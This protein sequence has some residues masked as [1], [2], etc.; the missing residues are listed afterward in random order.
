MADIMEGDPDSRFSSLAPIPP[1]DGPF[2]LG[3][4][5]RADNKKDKVNLGIGAYRDVPGCCRRPVR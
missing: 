3:A 5:F 2:A 1:L 4:V